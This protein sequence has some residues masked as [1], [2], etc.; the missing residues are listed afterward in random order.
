[1]VSQ[2]QYGITSAIQ[3]VRR[4]KN[5]ILTTCRWR[6]NARTTDVVATM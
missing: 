1:M 3:E 4:K 6:K 5:W 2:G